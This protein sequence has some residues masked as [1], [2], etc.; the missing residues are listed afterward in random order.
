MN[1]INAVMERLGGN[2]ETDRHY[3]TDALHH[4]IYY[5]VGHATTDEEALAIILDGLDEFASRANRFAAEHV[6]REERR[7]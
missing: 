3:M 7:S 1:L 5:Q 6:E 4:A 2:A